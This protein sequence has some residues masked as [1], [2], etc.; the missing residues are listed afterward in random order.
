M[1][2]C[3]SWAALANPMQRKENRTMAR[4]IAGLSLRQKV[5]VISLEAGL[6]FP[7]GCSQVLHLDAQTVALRASGRRTA[8][9]PLFSGT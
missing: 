2:V 6:R 3:T 8:N 4:P 9:F 1:M 7:T 5:A